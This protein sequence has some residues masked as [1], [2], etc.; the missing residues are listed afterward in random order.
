MIRLD[1]WE[2]GPTGV[3][4]QRSHPNVGPNL[5]RAAPKKG[6]ASCVSAWLTGGEVVS[7]EVLLESDCQHTPNSHHSCSCQ[8]CHALAG[9]RAPLYAGL[10]GGSG[11]PAVAGA[12]VGGVSVG[13]GNLSTCPFKLPMP[14]RWMRL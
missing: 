3:C 11:G 10:R 2:E 4:R 12:R 9:W 6:E 1:R 7:P 13:Q 8:D 5:S 14:Y